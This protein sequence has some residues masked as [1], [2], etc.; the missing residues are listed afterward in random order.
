MSILNQ[1]PLKVLDRALAK[2]DLPTGV[3]QLNPQ[4]GAREPVIESKTVE[5]YFKESGTQ[6]RVKVYLFSPENLTTTQLQALLNQP[7]KYLFK[8][9]AKSEF[10]QKGIFNFSGVFNDFAYQGDRGWVLLERVI[11]QPSPIA[12]KLLGYCFWGLKANGRDELRMGR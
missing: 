12:I 1:I 10:N 9:G 4:T 3:F 2:V 7:F 8:A 5:L 11:N 6:G